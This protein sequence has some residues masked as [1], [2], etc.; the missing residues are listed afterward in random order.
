M[1]AGCGG[2]A[3]PDLVEQSAVRRGPAAQLPRELSGI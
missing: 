1:R 2:E 3:K